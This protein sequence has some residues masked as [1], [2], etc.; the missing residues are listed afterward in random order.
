MI[1]GSQSLLGSLDSGDVATVAGYWWLSQ[2]SSVL[3]KD[4]SAWVSVS[5]QIELVPDLGVL[6][7]RGKAGTASYLSLQVSSLCVIKVPSSEVIIYTRVTVFFV[8][9]SELEWHSRNV[10][11]VPGNHFFGVFI[12]SCRFWQ[13]VPRGGLDGG[14]FR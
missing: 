2:S 12:V 1:A 6:G 3:N 5:V 13:S 14:Y 8:S 10:S 11:C 9:V 7:D 4:G